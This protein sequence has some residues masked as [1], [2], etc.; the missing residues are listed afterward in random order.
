MNMATKVMIETLN[1][2]LIYVAGNF[3]EYCNV[4]SSLSRARE[5]LASFSGCMSNIGPDS[6][7]IVAHFVYILILHIFLVLILSFRL[8]GGS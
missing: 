7:F 3:I 8:T 5:S 6:N 2:P 1:G 4:P